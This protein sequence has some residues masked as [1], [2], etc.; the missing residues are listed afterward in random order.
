MSFVDTLKAR[1]F[2][3]EPSEQ[4]MNEIENEGTGDA[5]VMYSTRFCPFC[6]RARALLQQ[7]GVRYRDI[8]V[9]GKPDLRREM[10]EKSGRHTVPQIW[11]GDTHVGGC[12]ELMQLERDG[13]LDAL[14]QH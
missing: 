3:A 13:K 2:S 1:I 14:L 4:A 8:A 10:A 12:D 7:K 5:V 11:I 6:M 9:D